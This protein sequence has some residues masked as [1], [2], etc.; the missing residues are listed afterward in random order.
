MWTA[1]QFTISVLAGSFA[2]WWDGYLWGTGHGNGIGL[3]LWG[4]IVG[5]SV[6]RGVMFLITWARFGLPAAR[7]MRML[8]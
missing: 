4:F 6:T 2:I 7:S 1:F 8:D 5:L 3:T